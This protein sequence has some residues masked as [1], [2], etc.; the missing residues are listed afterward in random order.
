MMDVPPRYSY[1]LERSTSRPAIAGDDLDE[2]KEPYA[3][4]GGYEIGD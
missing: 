3:Q 1:G 2:K 4:K